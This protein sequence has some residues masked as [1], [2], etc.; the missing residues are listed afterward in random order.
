MRSLWTLLLPA[1]LVA[2]CAVEG[3][4]ADESSSNLDGKNESTNF[5]KCSLTRAQIL[6]Q[7]SKE[8]GEAISRGFEWLDEKVPF[9]S[10]AKKDS[11]RTDCSG[12]VSMC[13]ELGAPGFTTRQFGK[14]ESKTS[15]V[16]SYDKLVPGDGFVLAGKHSF[17]FLGWNDAEKTGACVLE[18]SSTKND[19][20]FRVRTQAALKKDGYVAIRADVFKDD[21]TFRPAVPGEDSEPSPSE[22]VTP[23]DGGTTPTPPP[24]TCTP[25]STAELCEAASEA[26]GVEC[27]VIPNGCSGT[28]DCSTLT[29]FKCSA[30]QRCSSN[31]CVAQACTPKPAA[32]LCAEAK[33]S[34][35]IECGTIPTNCGGTVSC[36][37]VAGF[38]CAADQTC[39]TTTNKCTKTTTGTTPPPSTPSDPSSTSPTS[40]LSDSEDQGESAPAPENDDGAGATSAPKRKKKADGGCAAAPGTSG[41]SAALAGVALG[42]AALARRRSRRC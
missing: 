42:L 12:F 3:E 41:N 36:D 28:V 18:Q 21:L 24:T 17:L 16:D 2:A 39:G 32:E 6:A 25:K 20:Q 34:K 37:T 9:S 8:R 26:S 19:M 4:D 38:G 30:T 29:D 40:S 33:A 13:W 7:V 23:P 1:L 15:K 31:K 5:G 22:T 27:G 14:A 10:S 11:Y 35:G